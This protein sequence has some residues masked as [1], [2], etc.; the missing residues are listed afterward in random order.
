MYLID[1]KYIFNDFWQFF[2]YFVKILV[3]FILQNNQKDNYN[4]RFTIDPL[5]GIF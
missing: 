2:S 3:N 1:K 5:N 4:K